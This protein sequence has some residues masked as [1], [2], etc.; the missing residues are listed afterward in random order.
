[1]TAPERSGS[2]DV[3][4][5]AGVDF[6]PDVGAVGLLVFFV[7]PLLQ[8][9]RGWLHWRDGVGRCSRRR[10]RKRRE[11]GELRRPEDVN[12]G[13]A[14][15]GRNRA[16]LTALNTTLIGKTA[17]Q[18]EKPEHERLPPRDAGK[19]RTRRTMLPPLMN[20]TMNPTK[21]ERLN[22]T[23]PTP[24]RTN[25][26]ERPGDQLYFFNFFHHL[27]LVKEIKKMELGAGSAGVLGIGTSAPIARRFRIH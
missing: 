23:D 11:N 1:M 19:A 24:P 17:S 16:T 6:V 9:R 13:T 12:P 8:R 27:C 21:I 22:P 10:W 18:N 15:N 3:R 4:G 7:P 26:G 2:G 25:H 20:R 5:S 14:R